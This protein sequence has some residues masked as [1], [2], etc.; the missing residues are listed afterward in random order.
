VARTS[1]TTS[2]R[3]GRYY[4]NY[5]E[6]MDHFDTGVTRAAC[7]GSFYERMVED[8]EGEVRR[9]LEYCG[10]PVRGGRAAGSTRT[11][12]PCAPRVRAGATADLSRGDGPVAALRAV[13][14]PAEAVAWAR[15][16]A[17]IRTRPSFDSVAEGIHSAARVR[18]RVASSRFNKI[19]N[20][21]SHDTQQSARYP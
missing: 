12:G 1:L 14:R 17:D 15:P 7:T 10:L 8:T 18:E 16:R 13:A 6:L 9:L 4:R 5:V 19:Q 3:S 2:A 11:S 21:G 20:R